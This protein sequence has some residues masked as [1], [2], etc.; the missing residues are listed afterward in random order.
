L[1]CWKDWF[2]KYVFTKD[3]AKGVAF[4]T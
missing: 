2:P 3:G 1:F 4:P